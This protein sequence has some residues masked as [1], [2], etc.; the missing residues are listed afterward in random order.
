MFDIK[1][2][3]GY[4]SDRLS[5]LVTVEIITTI[6][7]SERGLAMRRITLSAATAA[8]SRGAAML[9][10][11]TIPSAITAK[12]V[13]RGS[14]ALVALG[15]AY[16][17][18]PRKQLGS[19]QVRGVTSGPE[20]FAI[21]STHSDFSFLVPEEQEKHMRSFAHSGQLA[22]YALRPI[23]RINGIRVGTAR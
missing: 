6:G 11:P 5:T 1:H 9:P 7:S 22:P 3:L 23:R 14:G 16:L 21:V 17:F 19:V 18:A 4:N 12:R 20:G 2:H 15:A 13:R 8:I 10:R